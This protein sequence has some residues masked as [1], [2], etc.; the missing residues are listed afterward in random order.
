GG[1]RRGCGGRRAGG[2]GRRWRPRP[3]GAARTGGRRAVLGIRRRPA[4]A[5]ASARAPRWGRGARRHRWRRGWALRGWRRR[6][7]RRRRPLGPAVLLLF[8]A[9][10]P[11]AAVGRTRVSRARAP[12]LRGGRRSISWLARPRAGGHPPRGA[13]AAACGARA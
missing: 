1:G 3:T 11:P 4:R 6:R 8:A 9:R 10:G 5:L 13:R 2:R 7:T 12:L